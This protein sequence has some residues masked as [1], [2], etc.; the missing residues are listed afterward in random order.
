MQSALQGVPFCL[1]WPRGH[2]SRLI[3]CHLALQTSSCWDISH[4]LPT[5]LCAL[6]IVL[7]PWFLCALSR[8]VEWCWTQG[9]NIRLL[10]DK[11]VDNHVIMHMSGHF[12][13]V[14]VRGVE[15]CLAHS[16]LLW[17]S[18]P[19][20]TSNGPEN[21]YGFVKMDAATSLMA[22]HGLQNKHHLGI[23]EVKTGTAAPMDS[24][25]DG[26]QAHQQRVC[27]Y[28]CRLQCT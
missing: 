17:M 21:S 6:D 28:M 13:C 8:N 22:G 11:V 5:R 12:V 19:A 18:I 2:G 4:E 23:Q 27:S 25:A 26:V 16:E 9:M 1:D 10:T 24:L 7:F 14:P 3:P 20:L 15:T